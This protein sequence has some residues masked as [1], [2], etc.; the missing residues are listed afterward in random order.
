MKTHTGHIDNIND[1][2]VY[3]GVSVKSASYVNRRHTVR[4]YLPALRTW[5]GGGLV[6][7]AAISI[8]WEKSD[9]LT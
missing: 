9:F 8:L 6:A 7:A 1:V 3:W 5:T 2:F 4:L